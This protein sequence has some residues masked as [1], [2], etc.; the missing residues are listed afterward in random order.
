MKLVE[1]LTKKAK[2][3]IFAKISK[4]NCRFKPN[5]S[6]S[7]NHSILCFLVSNYWVNVFT[8]YFD[9]IW[10]ASIKYQ[11]EYKMIFKVQIHKL[12]TKIEKLKLKKKTNKFNMNKRK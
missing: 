7:L 11:C 9:F 12:F 10:D 3:K 8:I 5:I 2:R 6:Y 1:K 4:K